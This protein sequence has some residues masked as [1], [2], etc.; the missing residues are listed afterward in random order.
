[1]N[2]RLAWLVAALLVSACASNARPLQFLSGGGAKYPPQAKAD[3][4][5]GYVVV[6]YDVDVDGNVKNVEVVEADPAGVFDAAAITAIQ[7]YR[8]KAPMVDGVSEPVADLRSR[9]VFKLGD[10]DQYPR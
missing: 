2:K 5:E 6:R 9:V 10:D 7:S 8:F 1:M 4:I 3:G